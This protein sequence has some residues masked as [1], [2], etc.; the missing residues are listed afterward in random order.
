MYF[1]CLDPGKHPP[2]LPT[3]P[4]CLPACL[5]V[6][7]A[8]PTSAASFVPQ[9]KPWHR[10]REEIKRGLRPGDTVADYSFIFFFFREGVCAC[11]HLLDAASSGLKR[12]GVPG[13]ETGIS[14]RTLNASRMSRPFLYY[15]HTT[16]CDYFGVFFFLIP[17]SCLHKYMN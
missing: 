9:P 12:G 15:S 1:L 11:Y 5:P 16:F 8:I 6:I 14:T 2:G 7:T 4:A 3:R 17:G 10:P 13:S